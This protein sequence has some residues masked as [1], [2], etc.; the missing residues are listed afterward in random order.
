MT[1]T[2][3]KLLAKE[4]DTQIAGFKKQLDDK[5][6]ERD[7]FLLQMKEIYD[8]ETDQIAKDSPSQ[9]IQEDSKSMQK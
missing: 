5:W 9:Q 8:V 6:E 7:E 3:D 2:L 1:E 4:I